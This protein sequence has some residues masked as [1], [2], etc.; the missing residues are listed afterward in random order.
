[1]SVDP[2]SG[3]GER[4]LRRRGLV[5]AVG[6]GGT[7]VIGG[8]CGFADKERVLGAEICAGVRFC[9]GFRLGFG[10]PRVGMPCKEDMDGAWVASGSSRDC[11]VVRVGD[12]KA[13][14]APCRPK[15]RSTSV[16]G[17]RIDSASLNAVVKPL[18]ESI[19]EDRELVVSKNET[20]SDDRCVAVW[21][22]RAGVV[23][24][25]ESMKLGV[26][27]L[28]N[29]SAIGSGNGGRDGTGGITS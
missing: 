5:V 14:S 8:G 10:N 28:A 21:S 26:S 13:D 27:L 17:V 19:G 11:G 7:R 22:V 18:G 23:V 15:A 16:L 6:V 3:F 1:M 9:E 24:L 29:R 20:S 25:D 12:C 2:V 4:G